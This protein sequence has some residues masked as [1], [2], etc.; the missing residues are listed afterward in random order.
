MNSAD[1]RRAAADTETL[2]GEDEMFA[3]RRSVRRRDPAEMTIAEVD[4]LLS[5]LSKN[6]LSSPFNET[7][8]ADLDL[9]TARLVQLGWP[10]PGRLVL[11]DGK[12]WTELSPDD[13]QIPL[14]IAMGRPVEHGCDFILLRVKPLTEAW[15]LAR[16][17]WLSLMIL[18][19]MDANR[20]MFLA[21]KLGEL[22][23]DGNFASD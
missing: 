2:I 22:R 19:E 18:E 13:P 1:K 3:V 9:W 10:S 17:S 11:V 15:W 23:Q 12:R 7:L 20:R 4:E 14:E 8:A 21:V 5:P 6:A 16:L